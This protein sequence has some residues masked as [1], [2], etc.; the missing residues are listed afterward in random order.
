MSK[1]RFNST[2]ERARKVRELVGQYYEP[3]RHDRCKLWV[4]RNIVDKQFGISERTFFRYLGTPPTK[5]KNP[6]QLLLFDEDED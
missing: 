4:F 1:K 5:E 6:F 3:G 2:E